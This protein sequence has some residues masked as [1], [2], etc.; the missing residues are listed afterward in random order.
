MAK[1]T[2]NQDNINPTVEDDEVD[3]EEYEETTNTATTETSVE[4]KPKLPPLPR[5]YA[6]VEYLLL[7]GPNTLYRHKNRAGFSTPAKNYPTGSLVK[8]EFAP[9]KMIEQA[10]NPDYI[11]VNKETGIKKFYV[12]KVTRVEKT[13]AA[14][15]VETVIR[16]EGGDI[17]IKTEVNPENYIHTSP[18]MPEQVMVDNIKKGRQSLVPKQKQQ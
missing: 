12:E 17:P 8:A 14:T 18:L 16:T 11:T 4:T 1:A 15:S 2:V 13:G 10:N 6:Y 7:N 9:P 3:Y 5:G